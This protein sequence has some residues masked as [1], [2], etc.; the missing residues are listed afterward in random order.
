MSDPELATR[1]LQCGALAEQEFIETALNAQQDTFFVFAPETGK[2]IQW[3]KMFSEISGYSAAEIRSMKAPGSYYSADDLTKAASAIEKLNDGDTAVLE[4]SLITKSGET[5]P[6][7]YVGSTLRDEKGAVQYIVAVGRNIGRRRHAEEALRQLNADMAQRVDERTMEC[8]RY[9]LAFENARDAILWAD[10]GTGL[11]LDC[12][13]AAERL[14]EKDR[15]EILGQHQ[16]TLH[17]PD[18]K[19]RYLALF[20]GTGSGVRSKR[21]DMAIIT[22]SGKKVSIHIA[23]SR[24]SVGD[25]SIIQG[26]FIDVSERVKAREQL[27]E[28]ERRYRTV[29]DFAYDWEWW[30]DPYGAYLYM[31][32]SCER[33]TGYT[34][35]EFL[36]NIDLLDDIILPEDRDVWEEHCED[37]KCAHGPHELQFRIKKKDGTVRWLEHVCQQV[38]TARGEFLGFRASSRDITQ[39][40]EAQDSVKLFASNLSQAQR[41]AHMGSWDWDIVTGELTWSDEVYRIFGLLPQSSNTTYAMFM[42]VV[43]PDDRSLVEQAVSAALACTTAGYAINHRVVRPDGTERVVHERGEVI[44]E[45]GKPVTMIGTIQDVTTVEVLRREAGVQRDALARVSRTVSMEKLAGSIAHEL[46]QP[47][48]GILSNAQAGGMMIERDLCSCDEM[49][50][51]VEEIV[52]DAK[53]A[54]AVIRNLRD[55]YRKQEGELV[56]VDLVALVQDTVSMLHSEFVLQEVNLDI[57]VPDGATVVKGNRV[58]L[59]Q[60]LLNLLSNAV[61]AMQ[62]LEEAERNLTVSVET[63]ADV[64]MVSVADCGAGI[65]ADRLPGIFEPL[66]TWKPG[67]T[68]MGLAI[69]ASIIKA[70]GGHMWAEDPPEGGARVGFR[71]SLKGADNDA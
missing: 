34:C 42:E 46:N 61:Q 52:A 30:R 3:N 37:A 49:K 71:I 39:R 23:T 4:M 70:H 5:I 63:V 45:G 44:R 50:T 69:S 14:F 26:T 35:E 19:D 40:R 8:E 54:G 65:G 33:I 18:E 7:E 67:G 6:T 16:S 29:A 22:K 47:L 12:N 57:Q 59:Q 9:R 10:A 28:A 27:V 36:G 41:I 21:D 56:P 25:T 1:E 51:V 62:E 53:R 20:A 13:A 43:H 11:I 60:V 24:I 17:P 38:R 15:D 32:P 2:A 58:Q 48:T 31:S 68:G 64:A 55:L 66:A